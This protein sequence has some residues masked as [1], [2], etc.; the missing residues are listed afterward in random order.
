M[1][2]TYGNRVHDHDP[3]EEQLVGPLRDCFLRGGVVV[4]GNF[5]GVHRGHQAILARLKQEAERVGAPTMVL[6]FYP[7]P[8]QVLRPDDPFVPMMS[9]KERCRRLFDLRIDHVLA[10]P[11]DDDLMEMTAAEFVDEILWDALRVRGVYVGG[12]TRFGHGREGDVK[13]L[14]SRGRQLGYGVESVRTWVREADAVEGVAGSDAQ[15][16]RELEAANKELSQ[17]LRELR[18]ANEVL[19]KASAY[20]AQAE[21]DRPS[22]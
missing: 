12:D 18:R 20:F 8:R 21:L 2:S 22:K 3:L 9:L 13:F 14:E 15:R 11:F 4:I 16:V 6:T 7:H 10:L 5:D 17:E 1:E 19:R